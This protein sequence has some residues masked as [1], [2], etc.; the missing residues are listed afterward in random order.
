LTRLATS[1]VLGYHGCD[2]EIARGAVAGEIDL[3]W[4]EKSYDWLGS[5]I[6]FWESDP[7]RAREW[8]ESQVKRGLY[9]KPA[10]IGAVIDLG[11]CLDLNAREN[12]QYLQISYE[13]LLR[14]IT[15]SDADMPV[16]KGVGSSDEDRRL[17]NLDCAV[18]NNLHSAIERVAPEK[19]VIQK[20]DTVRGMFVEGPP[21]YE[22]CAFSERAHVQIAVRTPA[23]IKGIF[24]PR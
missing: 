13:G 11:N 22:G 14:E 9:K 5:G 10:V 12:I 21:A 24:F 6:Y 3:L 1:F 8:A 19:R 15:N 23:C 4:S 20:F 17:R 16:N 2:A 18:I 7:D